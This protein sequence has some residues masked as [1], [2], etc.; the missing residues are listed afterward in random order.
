MSTNEA[1]RELR[2]KFDSDSDYLLVSR[3]G[4]AMKQLSEWPGATHWGIMGS[5]AGWRQPHTWQ[6]PHCG[7]YE[8]LVVWSGNQRIYCECADCTEKGFT[9]LTLKLEVEGERSPA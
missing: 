8:R 5:V 1:I 7:C 4:E 2:R 3:P 6:C 9:Q